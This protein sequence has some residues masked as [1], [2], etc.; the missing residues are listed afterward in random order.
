MIFSISGPPVTVVGSV[1]LE[2]VLNRNSADLNCLD[3]LLNNKK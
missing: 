2:N 1:H 3:Y